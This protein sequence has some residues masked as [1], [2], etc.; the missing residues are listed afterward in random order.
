MNPTGNYAA[1]FTDPDLFFPW[2]QILQVI[3][4]TTSAL[5]L[6]EG[7]EPS[8]RSSTAEGMTCPICLGHPIAPRMTKC[9]H[10]FCFPCILHYFQLSDIPKT[11]KCPICGDIIQERMLKAVRWGDTVV[12]PPQS[13]HLA[14]GQPFDDSHADH[15][16]VTGVLDLEPAAPAP[17]STSHPNP[18]SHHLEMRLILRPSS[19]T[20]ALP[21]SA[22]WPNETVNPA[23]STRATPW[24]FI[25]HVMTYAK[26]MLATCTYMLAELSR[27]MRELESERDGM[28]RAGDELGAVFVES[29]MKHVR[30]QME[31]SKGE[32]DTEGL[33]RAEREVR[34]ALAAL[35][36]GKGVVELEA[37]VAPVADSGTETV[38]PVSPAKS[39]SRNRRAPARAAAYIPSSDPSYLYYQSST[40]ANVFLHPLDIK[41]L[42]ARYKSYT[43]FP[44]TIVIRPQGADEGAINDDLRRRCKY[45]AHLGVGTDVVF[46][47][48]DLEETLG[49]EAVAPFDAALKMRRNRRR[50]RAKKDDKAKMRW[51][52]SEREKMPF[53][54]RNPGMG[55]GEVEDED[56]L[57]ALQR[58]TEEF[59]PQHTHAGSEASSPTTSSVLGTSFPPSSG[60]RIN[61]STSPTTGRTTS[62][63]NTNKS[64]ASALHAPPGTRTAAPRRDPE[65]DW[66][67]ERAWLAFEESAATA[68]AD[69]A[70]QR[71]G[72]A[73]TADD[74]ATPRQTGGKKTKPKKLVLSMSSGGRRA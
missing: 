4:P 29:A 64:W 26:F 7:H 42:L 6:A 10:I 16:P 20:L 65:A 2:Q 54:V 34:E 40:G 74:G 49:R 58:S 69:G 44:D 62:S 61:L 72:Q 43:G 73:V 45:L 23:T 27:D 59:G 66:E 14:D 21:R 47:E 3:V 41:I 33:R 48:A 9:G 1:H 53:G 68:R 52:A 36:G 67:M 17:A 18:T 15:D 37:P 28:M 71:D 51:E 55:I 8:S 13:T 5:A 50:D 38:A 57:V 32:M 35:E 56:F 70:S 60:T 30:G 12:S 39:K 31:K 24:H 46:V 22:T 11:A 25:P 63:Q 19:T